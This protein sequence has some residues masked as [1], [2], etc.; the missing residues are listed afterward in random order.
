[1][2]RIGKHVQILSSRQM[3]LQILYLIGIH[4]SSVWDIKKAYVIL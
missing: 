1:M 2:G 3:A 4:I